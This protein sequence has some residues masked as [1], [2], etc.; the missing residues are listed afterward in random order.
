[1]TRVLVKGGKVVTP[2]G[3]H[4][5]EVLIEKGVIVA[6]ASPGQ[7]ISADEVVDATGKVV[8]PGGIDGHTH[9]IENDPAVA[10]PHPEEFEGFENGSR[11]AAA[12]GVT[13]VIEM[14]QAD[15]PTVTAERWRRK[16][17]SAQS[18]TLVDFGLWGGLVPG[19]T[20]AERSELVDLGAAGFKAYMCGSDPSFSKVD[21]AQL[22]D[23]LRQLAPLGVVV[24]LHAEN[25]ALLHS[26]I[27]MMKREGRT[28]TLA[29]ADSRPPVVE[30]EAVNRA[31]FFAEQTGAHVHI[32]HMS[33]AG[34]ARL[35]G[36]AKRR[37]INV[38]CETTA[39]YLCLD[40]DDFAR[41]GPYG[42]VAPPLRSR[43]E[44]EGLWDHV[45]DG[46]IDCLASDHCAFTAESKEPGRQ[47][48]WD[49][50][51][52]LTGVQTN[53]PVFIDEAQR[54]GVPLSRI[55]AMIATGPSRVWRLGP[56]KGAI[57]VGRDGDL[58]LVDLAVEWTI[59]GRDLLQT[60]K[61][62]PFEGRA[63][64]VRVVRTLVRGT[65]VFLDGAEEPITV[66]PGFG[67]FVAS[68]H[69]AVT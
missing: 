26:G 35:V 29:H 33:S 25:D 21:D 19:Q 63:M 69:P 54:R 31:I 57:E 28:D 59:A 36:E 44:V 43:D 47:N 17:E 22:L 16:R 67:R 62:T 53:V 2:D 40:L 56:R 58:I 30:M 12:G 46:T 7:A 45:A 8:L 11:A 6:I 27:D 14:P 51:D 34:S 32:V 60:Q 42:R 55:A 48:I 37:G 52:G 68:G 3:V 15:P 61:W 24:G 18:S 5:R 1:M 38:T 66:A 13:T 9:F 50:P 64:Q 39:H 23:A 10:Q 20:A 4:E 49:A 41:L 65:T